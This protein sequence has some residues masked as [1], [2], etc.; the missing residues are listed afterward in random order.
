MAHILIKFGFACIANKALRDGII[1]MGK[2]VY[3]YKPQKPRQCLK[4]QHISLL[5]AAQCP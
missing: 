5:F 4:C 2:L 1:I 3:K